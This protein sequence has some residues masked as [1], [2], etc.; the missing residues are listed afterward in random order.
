[1]MNQDK[2]QLNIDHYIFHLQNTKRDC[3]LN[4]H[5]LLLPNK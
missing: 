5:F 4:N 1:M 2:N 3:N